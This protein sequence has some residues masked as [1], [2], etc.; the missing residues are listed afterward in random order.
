MSQYFFHIQQDG[1]STDYSEGLQFPDKEAARK[2][3]AGICDDMMRG[4]IAES[5]DQQEWLIDVSDAA[6]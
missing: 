4:V 6:E 1:H 3:A 2:E 5:E